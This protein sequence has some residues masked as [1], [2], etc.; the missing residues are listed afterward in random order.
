M[1]IDMKCDNCGYSLQIEDEICPHCGIANPFYKE[2]REN[3]ERYSREF[4]ETQDAVLDTTKKTAG[5]MIKYIISLV[6]I[7]VGMILL[8]FAGRIGN[9]KKLR[10][11]A[12]PEK[13]RAEYNEIEASGDFIYLN[14]WFADNRLN[15]IEAFEDC[16]NVYNVCMYYEFAASYIAEVSYPEYAENSV[17]DTEEYCE[18]I[19]ESYDQMRF[20]AEKEMNKEVSNSGHR[21]CI[22]ECLDKAEVLI[23]GVFGLT[24]EEMLGFDDESE[25]ER[26]LLLMENWPD[27]E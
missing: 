18:S 19:V 27:G 13:Y 20:Y 1:V 10:V 22:N 3:M 11:L 24:E 2:H 7:V 21:K 12:N 14:E 15:E 8:I 4:K 26:T 23:R 25:S 17:R 16:L 9:I 5:V 6:L